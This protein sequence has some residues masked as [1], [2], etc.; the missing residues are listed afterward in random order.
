MQHVPGTPQ[1][2]AERRRREEALAKGSIPLMDLP[3]LDS[4]IAWLR[5]RIQQQAAD[6]TEAS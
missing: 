1:D 2:L 5:D 4:E 6:T 3:V